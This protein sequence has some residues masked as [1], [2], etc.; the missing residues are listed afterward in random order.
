MYCRYVLCRSAGVPPPPPPS[1]L[2][3]ASTAGADA[4]TGDG[5][6]GVGVAGGSS[7]DPWDELLLH[8]ENFIRQVIRIRGQSSKQVGT[9]REVGEAETQ[10]GGGGVLGTRSS[11]HADYADHAVGTHVP[12]PLCQETSQQ[13]WSIYRRVPIQ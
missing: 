8:D 13:P 5:Q 11:R 1:K 12:S 10:L 3:E 9:H 4:K 2:P 7:P 6:S